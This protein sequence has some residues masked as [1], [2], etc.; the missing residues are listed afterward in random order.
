MLTLLQRHIRNHLLPSRSLIQRPDIR[1]LLLFLLQILLLPLLF[2]LL[3]LTQKLLQLLTTFL[4]AS[5][6]LLVFRVLE[7]VNFKS[8]PY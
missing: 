3:L 8:H 5:L 6:F 4:L 2:L 1:L 7:N